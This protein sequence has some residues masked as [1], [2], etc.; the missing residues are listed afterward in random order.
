MRHL[1]RRRAGRLKGSTESVFED[2]FRTAETASKEKRRPCMRV[3][4]VL[5]SV[6]QSVSKL[7]K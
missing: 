7:G 1:Q 3:Y 2:A 6:R 5:A 4:D